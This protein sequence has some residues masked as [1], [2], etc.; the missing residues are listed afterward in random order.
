MATGRRSTTTVTSGSHP[1]IA[2][3]FTPALKDMQ[4][5]LGKILR[6]HDDGST[7]RNNP[8][9]RLQQAESV[10]SANLPAFTDRS[11][12]SATAILLGIAFD[13]EG[14]LFGGRMGPKG[15]DSAAIRIKRAANYGY[16]VVS[17]GDHYDGRPIP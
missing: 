11:G 2:K 8:S 15:G 5:N 4:T 7:P 1:A 6:L 10:S 16:P 17:N 3:H 14:R 13:L 9:P 12:L